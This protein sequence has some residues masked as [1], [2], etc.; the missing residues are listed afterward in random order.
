MQCRIQARWIQ[1]IKKK[2]LFF[3]K[4]CPSNANTAG[5]PS[6]SFT[7]MKMRNMS[8]DPA[9]G[10]IAT[11][12]HFLPSFYSFWGPQTAHLGPFGKWEMRIWQSPSLYASW[13]KRGGRYE[14]R[15][16]KKTSHPLLG[17]AECL[18]HT[19]AQKPSSMEPHEE[20]SVGREESHLCGSSLRRSSG[21]L[22]NWCRFRLWRPA[23]SKAIV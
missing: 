8:N 2:N 15:H 23:T 19:D 20:L 3:L 1:L 14:R 21:N 17:C 9:R 13:P 12:P 18:L 7:L 22:S 5:K 11:Q 6:T 16:G 4:G 10:R